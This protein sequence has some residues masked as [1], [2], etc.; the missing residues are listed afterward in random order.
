MSE[1]L[2]CCWEQQKHTEE[3]EQEE[4]EEEELQVLSSLRHLF[5]L[6]ML[7]LYDFKD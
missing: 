3:E 5:E 1:R 7:V 6:H 4:E 2:F